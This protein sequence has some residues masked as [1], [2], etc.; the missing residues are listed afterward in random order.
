MTQK[1]G[2]AVKPATAI[3]APVLEALNGPIASAV[4]HNSEA[5]A[6]GME[7]VPAKI[8]EFVA[9]RIKANVQFYNQC[10]DCQDWPDLMETQQKWLKETNEAYAQQFNTILS[11][12][13]SFFGQI[14]AAPNSPETRPS[15][16]PAK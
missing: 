6:N 7:V 3:P 5:L 16:K 4:S 14:E 10:S 12:T 11:M 13:Q 2:E 1:T 15:Q 9:N 8:G